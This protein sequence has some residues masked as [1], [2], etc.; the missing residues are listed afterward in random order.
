MWLKSLSA[1]SMCYGLVRQG[2]LLWRMR[3]TLLFEHN[4]LPH[5]DLVNA[6][7][8]KLKPDATIRFSLMHIRSFVDN[9]FVKGHL[10]PL[11]TTI[12]DHITRHATC[13]SGCVACGLCSVLLG[14]SFTRFHP[15]QRKSS[16]DARQNVV[17]QPRIRAAIVSCAHRH[18]LYQSQT[19]HVSF[20]NQFGQRVKS[21][22][23]K[24]F[25]NIETGQGRARK[26]L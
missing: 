12:R 22:Y 26:A 13:C 18:N 21:A 15:Q 16:A 14:V 4:W 9:I 20:R 3:D 25:S 1:V 23:S 2:T 6:V 17:H 5:D 24:V 11:S 10:H 7:H 19:I 8:K